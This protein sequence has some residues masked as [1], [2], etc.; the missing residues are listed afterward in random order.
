VVDSRQ[1]DHFNQVFRAARKTGI[2]PAPEVALEHIGFGTMNGRDGKPFKT[3]A[4][5]VMKLKDLIQMLI[6]KALERM[7]EAEV[8]ENYS[9]EE[10][11]GIARAIGVSALKFG[12]L[13]NQPS[14]DYVFDLDR[15]ASFEGKTGPYLLYTAVRIKSI[16]R[17]AN[18]QGLSVGPLIPPMSDNERSILLKL[19]ALPDQLSNAFSQRAPHYLCDYAYDLSSAYSAFYRDHH[20][21]SEEDKKRQASWLE[22]S[23]LSLSAVELVTNLLGIELPERM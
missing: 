4:G 11:Q 15:F 12:D 8:A 17:K 18:E 14:K 13:M 9:Q 20:I 22:L 19:A 1:S 21:L 6:D 3:R 10:K 7:K 23:R 5:G 16:L 2:A